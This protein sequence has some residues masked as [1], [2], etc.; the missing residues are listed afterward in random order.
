MVSG[1]AHLRCYWLILTFHITFSL[2]NY[3][4]VT[5]LLLLLGS[6][7]FHVR[8][9]DY[10]YLLHVSHVPIVKELQAY[11]LNG[12]EASKFS[13]EILDFCIITQASYKKCFK[14]IAKTAFLAFFGG[15]ICN[16]N[17]STL[18]KN[19]TYP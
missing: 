10:S 5:A 12:P 17:I 9:V 7:I 1:K 8:I 16:S 18:F 3:E 6:I 13:F 15:F 19:K 4:C 11:P 2:K 14:C